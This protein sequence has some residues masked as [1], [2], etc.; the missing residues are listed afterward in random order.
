MTYVSTKV[1]VASF[2]ELEEDA[3]IVFK[4][5]LVCSLDATVDDIRHTTDDGQKLPMSQ[6][7]R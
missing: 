6:R 1:Y 4:T 5:Q 2:N 3:T 7:L